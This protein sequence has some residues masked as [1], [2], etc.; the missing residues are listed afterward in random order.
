MHL[1]IDQIPGL[2]YHLWIGL[3]TAQDF[4]GISQWSKGITKFVRQD[5]QELVPM[6]IGSGQFRHSFLQ[7]FLRLGERAC[8]GLCV[9]AQCF[10]L[11]KRQLALAIEILAPRDVIEDDAD[12]VQFRRSYPESADLEMAMQGSC[13]VLETES[14]PGERDAP[15]NIEPVLFMIGRNLAHQAAASVANARLLFKCMVDFEEPIV[16]RI[17]HRVENHFNDAVALIHR[18]KECAE[19]SLAFLSRPLGLLA[20]SDIPKR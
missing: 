14:F 19:S 20:F 11:R 3:R 1:S 5:G 7:R 8:S 6:T 15:I 12:T 18:L 2:F 13:R 16:N 4:H 10:L 17:V 9:L